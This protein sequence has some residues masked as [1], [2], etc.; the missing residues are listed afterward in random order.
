ME[1]ECAPMSTLTSKDARTPPPGLTPAGYSKLMLWS[2]SSDVFI[3][4]E[5]R[6]WEWKSGVVDF[7]FDGTTDYSIIF[8][9]GFGFLESGLTSASVKAI[10]SSSSSG[11]NRYFRI[12]TQRRPQRPFP[13]LQGR[14]S[15]RGRKSTALMGKSG[16]HQ[17]EHLKRGISGSTFD[18]EDDQDGRDVQS[19]GV[20]SEIGEEEES[21]A[22]LRSTAT[23]AKS[24]LRETGTGSSSDDGIG[25]ARW[26]SSRL[27]GVN[28]SSCDV[29]TKKSTRAL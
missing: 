6:I 22:P 21:V 29:R 24:S 19:E 13:L 16:D 7:L 26:K 17:K 12:S 28:T 5:L 18:N 8:V 14:A 4:D 9:I 15:R 10:T 3:F 27:S 25:I 23:T 1:L 2:A 11:K 20:G